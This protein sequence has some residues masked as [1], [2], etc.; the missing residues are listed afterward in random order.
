MRYQA[1]LRPEDHAKVNPCH[2]K[3]LGRNAAKSRG[4][5]T[6]ELEHSADPGQGSILDMSAALDKGQVPS[7][8]GRAR[9]TKNP[10][11][12]S[13]HIQKIDRKMHRDRSGP[14]GA[15]GRR[16]KQSIQKRRQHASVNDAQS[17]AMAAESKKSLLRA[18]AADAV[19]IGTVVS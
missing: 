4:A 14:R 1:A 17:V 5:P 9:L 2:G 15:R 7:H 18:F 19:I 12:R 8:A 11:A 13:P 3:A 6:H 16:C 10:L